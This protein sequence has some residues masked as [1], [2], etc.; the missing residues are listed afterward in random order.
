MRKSVRVQLPTLATRSRERSSSE[1]REAHDV[2]DGDRLPMVR[3]SVSLPTLGRQRSSRLSVRGD[4]SASGL[5]FARSRRSVGPRSSVFQRSSLSN[6]AGRRQPGMADIGVP[7]SEQ[8]RLIRERVWGSLPGVAMEERSAD[9]VWAGYAVLFKDHEDE[10]ST[11]Q[12]KS[13]ELSVSTSTRG[14]SLGRMT[15]LPRV[16]VEQPWKPGKHGWQR[17]YLSSKTN[18]GMSED[19]G[20]SL[21]FLPSSTL[22]QADIDFQ[23]FALHAG[24]AGISTTLRNA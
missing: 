4:L 14:L 10:S 16:K 1:L 12:P 23:S 11:F 13:E 9:Q 18:D 21:G 7:V 24:A 2:L 17:A 22:T 20:E 8:A 19:G 5:N 3:K 15:A 6:L